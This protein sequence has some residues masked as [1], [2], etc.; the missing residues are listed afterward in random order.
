MDP[1]ANE[2]SAM[3]RAPRARTPATKRAALARAQAREM[4]QLIGHLRLGW[5][6]G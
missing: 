3:D 4:N 6:F 1:R 5:K 2:G